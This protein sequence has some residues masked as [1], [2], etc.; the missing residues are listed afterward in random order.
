[1]LDQFDVILV[2]CPPSLGM[3]SYISLVATD[4]LL[5]PIQTQFKAFQGTDMLLQTLQKH[6]CTLKGFELRLNRNE[7]IICCD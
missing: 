5:I 3:L 4:Y 1:M 7:Q 2:D 6:I